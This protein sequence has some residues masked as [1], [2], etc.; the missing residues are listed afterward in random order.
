M[1]VRSDC[2][3]WLALAVYVHKSQRRPPTE[4]GMI[5]KSL[6]SGLLS[7]RSK[8]LLHTSNDNFI[9]V[10]I[11][12]IIAQLWL[13]SGGI[14]GVLYQVREHIYP[15]T[16]RSFQWMIERL[17]FPLRN[18]GRSNGDT[19]HSGQ[20]QKDHGMSTCVRSN[21]CSFALLFGT[22]K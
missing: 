5:G 13:S 7:K 19:R 16:H 6:P 11:G 14:F 3:V 10:Y 21:R 1:K 18:C 17:D 2:R 8:S 15:S 9:R 22:S 12:S 4:S 20:T